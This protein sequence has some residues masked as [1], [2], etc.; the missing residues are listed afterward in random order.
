MESCYHHT[1]AKSSQARTTEWLQT[2]FHNLCIVQ[3]IWEALN[4]DVHLPGTAST[5]AGTLLLWSICFSAVRIHCGGACHLATYG[6]IKPV[7]QWVCACLYPGLF[8]CIWQCMPCWSDETMAQ[9]ALP[10]QVYNLI[11][12]IFP[13]HS[14]CTNFSGQVS[15]SSYI[16]ASAIQDSSFGPALFLVSAANVHHIHG[17]NCLLKFADDTYLMSLHPIHKPARKSLQT[18]KTGQQ[19][20]V[21]DSLCKV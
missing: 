21:Y 2:N 12:D 15:K 3:G 7:N 17:G 19:R 4:Q 9:L 5:H 18:S 6:T 1:I 16:S 14:H 11:T 10:D 20:T 13:G 8:P